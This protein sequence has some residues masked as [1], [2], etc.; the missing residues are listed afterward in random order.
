MK[1]VAIS[2]LILIW[3]FA[4]LTGTI[5]LILTHEWSAW[6]LGLAI[7]IALSPHYRDRD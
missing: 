5:W 4:V 3:S 2:A 1:D 7:P 6:W